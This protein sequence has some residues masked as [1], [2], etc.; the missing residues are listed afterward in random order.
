MYTIL[1]PSVTV[2]EPD[3]GFWERREGLKLVKLYVGSEKVGEWPIA[4]RDVEEFKLTGLNYELR[5]KA[6]RGPVIAV[7]E[8]YAGN[9]GAKEIPGAYNP[10]FCYNKSLSQKNSCKCAD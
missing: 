5:V 10:P 1:K 9:V 6:Q 3:I 7:A 8:D 2:D 4:N